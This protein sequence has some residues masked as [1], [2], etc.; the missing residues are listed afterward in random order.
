M[1]E[2]V[3]AGNWKMNVTVCETVPLLE[4]LMSGLPIA[5]VTSVVC[6]SFVSL[7]AANQILAESGIGLG[8]Q[9][10]RPEP[11]G[12][13]TGEV[14]TSMVAELCT[15][16]ILGH[17]ER[18]HVFGE[19]S[20]LV[21]SK[22]LS[23]L[24]VGLRPIVCVGETLHERESGRAREIVVDQLKASLEGVD[25]ASQVLVAYEPVWAI[26]TGRAASARDAQQMAAVTR[27]ELS[28]LFGPKTASD[29]PVL[30]GGSVNSENVADFLAMPDIDGALVGGASLDA[31]GF[32]RLTENA[33]PHR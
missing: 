16:V 17:S 11:K 9:D 30:Y 6:P 19:T 1:P 2:R 10:M 23:A 32:I 3:I 33:S 14:S 21:N 18:R 25:R 27:Y 20:K 31:E 12:P 22:A 29:V 26:G 5:G 15:Y 24:S 13:L 28:T 7:H 8:A 4:R